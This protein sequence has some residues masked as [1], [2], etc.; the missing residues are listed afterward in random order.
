MKKTVF[1]CQ[2]SVN[3]EVQTYEVH[4]HL[5]EVVTDEVVRQGLG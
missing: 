2:P 4:I 1:D 5:E 3:F